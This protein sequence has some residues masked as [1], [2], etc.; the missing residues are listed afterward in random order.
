MELWQFQ[1]IWRCGIFLSIFAQK[2]NIPYIFWGENSAREYGGSKKDQKIK[3]LNDKWI[4]K[5]GVNFGTTAKD[6]IDKDLTKKEMAPFFKY[7]PKQGNREC[8]FNFFLE[9]TYHGIHKK[10]LKL[11]KSMV[12]KAIQEQRQR[13]D[14][15]STPTSMII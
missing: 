15:I 1:C 4:K 6:W 2:F 10:V 5:Y 13:L 14:F 9:I 8:N 3:N 12:F 7:K 11:L